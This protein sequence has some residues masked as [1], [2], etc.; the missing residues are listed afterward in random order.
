MKTNFSLEHE[1]RSDAYICSRVCASDSYAQNL[2]A[3]LCNNRFQ[4]LD[5]VSVLADDL[6]S[7]SWRY[8]GGIISEIRGTG[9]YID[10]YCTGITGGDEPEVY[11]NNTLDGGY[12]AESVVTDEIRRDLLNL[13]WAVRPYDDED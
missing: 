4:K 7:C 3:A 5:V 13:G 9:S 12:V 1:L 10:W 8:A 11:M 2:Y 6:W